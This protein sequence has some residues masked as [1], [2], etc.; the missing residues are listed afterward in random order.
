ML[1]VALTGG[2]GAGKTAVAARLAGYGAVVVDADRLAREAVRPGSDGLAAVVEAFGPAVLA[3]DGSLDRAGLATVVFT[4]QDARAR[5]EAIVH[6]RVAAATQAAVAA[7][8]ADAVVVVDVPLLAESGAVDDYDLVV[9][10]DAD[11]AVR[12]RRLVQGRAMAPS[13]VRARMAAQASRAARLAIADVVITNNGG[14]DDLDAQ[15]G[16]LWAELSSRLA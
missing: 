1:R 15:V 16:E 9:V 2:I 6:P 10:V 7:A 3:D 12:E 4:D 13:D 11:E 5:L 14:L 8:P